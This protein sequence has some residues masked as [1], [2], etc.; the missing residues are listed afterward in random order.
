MNL[1]HSY[2]YIHSEC[3]TLMCRGRAHDGSMQLRNIGL[4]RDGF[5]RGRYLGHWVGF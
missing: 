1:G 4:G 3:A 2:N 5:R